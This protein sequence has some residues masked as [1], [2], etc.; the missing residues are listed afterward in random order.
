M[1]EVDACARAR[2]RRPDTRAT[3]AKMEGILI[4]KNDS[5]RAAG[6]LWGAQRFSES[7]QIMWGIF[8]GII[9]AKDERPGSRWKVGSPPG[10]HSVL[11]E[12]FSF[13]RLG[14][15]QQTV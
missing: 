1:S 14:T 13:A 7:M 10:S 12:P 5:N 2:G 3:A 9:T 11:K 15:K 6:R 8:L 4:V